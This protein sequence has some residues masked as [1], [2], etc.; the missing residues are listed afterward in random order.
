MTNY[1]HQLPQLSDR[2]FI[3][4]AGLETVLLFQQGWD[5][6]DFASFTLLD[7]PLGNAALRNYFDIYGELAQTYGMGLVLEAPT[8]RA[9]ADWGKRQ[10]YGA[11]ELADVNRR[12]IALLELT[13]NTYDTSH[14][15]IVLSGC[16]GP[17]GDGYNPDSLMSATEAEQYHQDQIDTFRN[18]TADLITAMTITYAEEAIGIVRAAQK[19]QMPVVISFTVETDGKLP[20]GMSLED[21]INSV[22]QATDGYPAYYMI[23]CAHPIHFDRAILNQGAWVERIRGIRA[24]ASMMS[25]AELDE[26]ET[27]DDGNPQDLGERFYI[28]KQQ[29]PHLTVLGGCCGTDHRHIEAICKVCG[30]VMAPVMAE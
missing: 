24:N 10:G 27:L 12:A 6:P 3:T 19:A 16:I 4:D 15:P 20:T 28:L 14:T 8:W 5:L 7:R 23:N 2:V 25:H 18:T 1:R 22:D 21:A 9:H 26:A 30:P 29:L 13:R 17:R 11:A